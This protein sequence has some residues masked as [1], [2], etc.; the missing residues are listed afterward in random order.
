MLTFHGP[1]PLGRF[2]GPVAQSSRMK[3]AFGGGVEYA[4]DTH[5]STR[6]EYLF[7]NQALGNQVYDNGLGFQ[8]GAHEQNEAHLLRFGLNYR[9]SDNNAAQDEKTGESKANDAEP[10]QTKPAGPEQYSVHAQVTNVAQ[11]YPKFPAL[12][13]G[14]NSFRSKGQARDGST[15]DGFFGARL[16][17]GGEAYVNPEIDQGFGLSNSVGA[18]AYVNGAVAKFGRSAPYLRFQ[19]YFLRQ[20][21]GLGGESEAVEGGLNQLAGSVDSN[22]LTFTVGKFGVP[23]IFDDNKYAHDA[24]NTFLNFAIN[25]MGAFDYAADSWGYTYGAAMEWK[26]ESW[27]ARA[28]VFQLSDIPNSQKIEPVLLRQFM[29]IFEIEKRYELFDQPGK[30]KFLAFGDR[31][32]ISKID[33]VINFAFAT[34]FFPPDINNMRKLQFKAGVGVNIEQQLTPTLGFFLRASMADGRFETVDYTDID[35]SI[36]AGFSLSGQSWDRPNDTIG[37]AVAASGLSNSRIRYFGLGGTS[38]YIGDGALSYGGEQVF[39]TFY[40]Y[41]VM[42]GVQVTVDYQFLH[43]PA[44]NLDRG[45]ISVFAL[46]LHGEF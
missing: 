36:S 39:E 16:W 33:D 40:K 2:Y 18:A 46:R 38:V 12:Y 22:R 24:T 7:V 35:R 5:W 43:N 6:F 19:R 31:G 11:G 14:P 4:L 29:P 8:L 28:G 17:S 44:H 41:N 26:Q 10:N 30:I 32:Y 1:A 45:P 23:D 34:R 20:T 37:A 13:D 3:Y 9:F 42:D 27:T 25:T 21:I 15:A